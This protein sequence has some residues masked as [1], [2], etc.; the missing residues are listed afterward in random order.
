MNRF[1]FLSFCFVAVI[2]VS[3]N[4]A[5]DPRGGCVAYGKTYKNGESYIISSG[6]FGSL[7]TYVCINGTWYGQDGA[8]T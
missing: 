5:H 3:A 2:L 6:D 8:R 1:A 4:R 7:V